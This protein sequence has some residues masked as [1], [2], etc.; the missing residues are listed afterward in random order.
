MKPLRIFIGVDY[1]EQ[2]AYHVLAQSIIHYASRPVM[3]TPIITNCIPE[4]ARPHDDRQSNS[5]SFSRF[6]VP[7]WC[8]YDDDLAIFMDCDMMFRADPYDLIDLIRYME[9]DRGEKAVWCV[10]H[11]YTPISARKYLGAVQHQY[12]RKNW[13]SMMVFRPSRCG[14][15]T[16][17]SVNH[18]DPAWLHR[19]HWV[20][21]SEIGSLPLEWNHLVDE[22][23][24]NP[25]AKIVHWTLYGPYFKPDVEF[26]D[27]WLAMKAEMEHVRGWSPEDDPDLYE[28]LLRVREERK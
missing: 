28:T 22:Y 4:Y 18:G 21:D 16:P 10:Q 5:F 26:S 3:I 23:A 15:L 25:R 27:E 13:S 2:V 12:P 24:P 8:D 11:D 14:A 6:L 19:M 9:D 7:H 20:E 1:V 17:V